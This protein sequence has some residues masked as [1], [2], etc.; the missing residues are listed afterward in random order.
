MP[1]D[2]LARHAAMNSAEQELEESYSDSAM[3]AEYRS[4]W[5]NENE[6]KRIPLEEIRPY[7]SPDGRPQPYRIQQDKVQRIAE[8][9]KD[10][11]QLQII[12][13]RPVQDPDFKYEVLSGHHRLLGFK[14]AG[15]ASALC[16]IREV[17]DKTAYK[18]VAES[19]T[20]TG[21]FLPTEQGTI[22]KAYMDLRGQSEEEKTAKE[23]AGKFSVSIRTIYRYIALLDLIPPLQQAVNEQI[24]PLGLFENILSSL[25]D[26]QQ[27]ALADYIEI[28]A[29]N[30]LSKKQ[31][32]MLCEYTGENRDFSPN[33]IYELFHSSSK[34][35]EGG[36]PSLADEHTGAYDRASVSFF[37]EVRAI[38]SRFSHISDDELAS[39]ILKTLM[40][41]I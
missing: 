5:G 3:A 33:E 37:N 22:Y 19:N 26:V 18:I 31:I 10:I 4:L 28:Y 39:F 36:E 12:A 20:P 7:R 41:A 17:D 34:E 14:E 2:L 25:T 40:E 6:I 23:I 35:S 15:L 1:L 16:E 24:I 9:A 13:V 27:Q 11:G 38:H 29:P 30:K 32:R 21:E 8:S